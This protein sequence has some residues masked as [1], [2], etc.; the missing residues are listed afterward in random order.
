MAQLACFSSL[1]CHFRIHFLLF[2]YSLYF[3]ATIKNAF[4][5]VERLSGACIEEHYLPIHYCMIC[6]LVDIGYCTYFPLL[7]KNNN[8]VIKY[9][10][11]FN[12]RK[13]NKLYLSL[14][15]TE[16]IDMNLNKNWDI[17]IETKYS[18]I[19]TYSWYLGVL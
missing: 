8:R 7:N 17:L 1:F 18:I 5:Q 12:I 4:V 2:Y 3:I 16:L 14:Q 11:Q 9:F 13:I 10:A 19:Y 15:K 6:T